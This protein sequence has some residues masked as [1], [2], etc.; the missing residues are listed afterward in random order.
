M[1]V[2]AGWLTGEQVPQEIIEQTLTAMGEVLA[3]HGG[4]PARSIYPGAGLIAFADTAYAQQQSK[5]PP[6]LDWVPDRRTLV[7][8]RP[9]SGVHPLFYI[10]N[11]PAEGNLL[12]ASE[13]KALF[14]VGVP[15][16]LHVAALDALWHYGSIP[17]PWTALKDIHV[18]PAGSILRWQHAK[19][20]VNAAGDFSLEAARSSTDA[21][22]QL[23]ALLN[24]IS[25][26]HLPPHEQVVALL[27]GSRASSLAAALSARQKGQGFASAVLSTSETLTTKG[28]KEVQAVADTYDLPLLAITAVDQPT[29]WQAAVLGL[30][31]PCCDSRPLAI[32]QLLHTIMAETG[33][34]VAISGLGAQT[35]LGLSASQLA[36]GSADN[37]LASYRQRQNPHQALAVEQLWSPSTRQLLQTTE[38]WEDTLHARKLQRRA[39]QYPDS[40]QGLYYLDLHLRLAN[41]LVYPFY[42]LAIQERMAIRSPYLN[43]HIIT[44]LI[45]ISPLLS[46][47]PE[48]PNALDSLLQRYM[49][50]LSSTPNVL[51]LTIPTTSIAHDNELFELTL[52]P[53][54]I[55]RRGIFDLEAVQDLQRRAAKDPAVIR[56]LIFVFTTQLFCHLFGIEEQA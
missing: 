30:E 51:P 10:E 54:A 33:A 3:H 34:R 44:S 38:G 2:L 53:A 25:H 19:T 12:F 37:L 40:R 52:A 42:Q 18:V 45:S 49:P 56:A 32:H 1:A 9:L 15:R 55:Q 47:D 7:Y 11:W 29:Y 46:D 13:I 50:G 27:S 26:D 35:L 16:R 41:E 48:T 28:W 39:Q 20:V 23:D 24:Q 36:I 8:R 17:A 43:A 21:L 31:A 4:T 22:E 6:V 14:A 5:E